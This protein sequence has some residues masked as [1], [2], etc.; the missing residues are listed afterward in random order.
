MILPCNS[1]LGAGLSMRNLDYRIECPC[2][3]DRHSNPRFEH[4]LRWLSRGDFSGLSPTVFE[5]RHGVYSVDFI[6]CSPYSAMTCG[7]VF[8]FWGGVRYGLVLYWFIGGDFPTPKYYG[9]LVFC[10]RGVVGVLFVRGARDWK[11]VRAFTS[12]SL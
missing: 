8:F 11:F 2:F 12:S 7:F 10:F 9:K 1:V 6:R 5:R 3:R 4:D